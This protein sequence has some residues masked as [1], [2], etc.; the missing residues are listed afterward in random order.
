MDTA[1]HPGERELQALTG[2]AERMAQVGP[3]VIR[4][5]MP[6]QHRDFFPLLPFVVVAAVDAQGQP[7]ASLVTGAPGFAHSPHERLLR[8]DAMPAAGDP[9]HGLLATGAPVG[10]LGIQAHTRRRNRLNGRAARLDARGFDLE[11][12]QSFGNCPKY[13]QAREAVFDPHAPPPGP[14]EQGTRL[15]AAAAATIRAADTFFIAT[16]HPRAAAG[17]P[18]AFGVDASHRGGPPGFVHVDGEVLLTV[19]DYVGNAFF[20]TLGN[21]RLNPRCGLL[22]VDFASGDALWVR[23]RA[24]LI[25]DEDEVRRHPG[26]QRLLRLAVEAFVRRPHAFPLRW[27]QAQPAPEVVRLAAA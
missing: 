2:V 24:E 16:A 4:D 6:Q 9:L 22:F 17:A 13:I 8:I 12:G 5:H 25:L 14:L 1:F 27:G 23:A 11:V 10:L 18:P 20:N 7:W 19:P 15:D 3:R 26:A 21:L